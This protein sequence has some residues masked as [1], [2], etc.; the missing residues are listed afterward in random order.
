MNKCFWGAVL[1][2][3][4]CTAMAGAD[5]MI[6]IGDFVVGPGTGPHDIDVMVSPLGGGTPDQF[7]DLVG[8]LIV[9]GGDAAAPVI[10]AVVPG[11]I[12]AGHANSGVFFS[13]PPPAQAVDPQISL[14]T[15]GDAVEANGSLLTFTL[16]ITGVAPGTYALEA[17]NTTEWFA[18]ML[19]QPGGASVPVQFNE[20]SITITPEPGTLVL[21][22]IGLLFG[23]A[24]MGRRRKSKA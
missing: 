3:L 17:G 2:T 19:F 1:M 21:S 8:G 10:T 14:T 15:P 4:A 20:G 11:T 6:S 13:A 22:T 18:T 16:D 7:T 12:Y 9:G 23:L 5:T 24:W